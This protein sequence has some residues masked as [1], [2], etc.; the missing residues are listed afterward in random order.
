[1][2]GSHRSHH[3]IHPSRLFYGFSKQLHSIHF[4]HDVKAKFHEF[5]S[6]LNGPRA[7]EI[8]LSGSR[9][10]NKSWFLRGS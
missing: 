9:I 8:S 10:L 7:H 5:S 2:S 1:M 4:S 3:L 6:I